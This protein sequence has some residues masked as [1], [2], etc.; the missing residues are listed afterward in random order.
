[1]RKQLTVLLLMVAYFACAQT[2]TQPLYREGQV[3]VKIKSGYNKT[4]GQANCG[5]QTVLQSI[6]G[7]KAKQLMPLSGTMTDKSRKASSRDN[8]GG[9]TDLSGLY[10]IHFD[11]KRSVESTIEALKKLG[12]VAYAEP[13]YIIKAIGMAPKALPNVPQPEVNEVSATPSYNDPNYSEQWGLQAINMPALWEKPVINST[14]P[15]IAV[16]DTGVDIT[17][18]DLAANIWTNTAEKG[19]DE[20]GNGFVG[21]VHG[22][23]FIE[24]TA[25]ITDKNNHGTHCAGIA[26]AVGNNGKGIVGANPNAL[27]MPVRVLDEAALGDVSIIIQGIDYAIANGANVISMSYGYSCPFGPSEAERDALLEASQ[28]AILVAAAGNNGVCMNSEHQGLHGN[29]NMTPMPSYPAAFRFVIGVQASDESGGL[30]SFS[31]FDCG[32]TPPSSWLQEPLSYEVTAPGNNIISTVSGGGYELMNGTSMACP[33]VAGAISSLMQR[34]NF[35]SNQELLTA[36]ALTSQTGDVDMAAVYGITEFPKHNINEVFTSNIDGVDITFKVNTVNTVQVGDGEN[37]AIASRGVKNVTIPLAVDGFQVVSIGRRAFSWTDLETISLPNSLKYFDT[38]A[39]YVANC[40]KELRI[41][42]SV[43]EIGESS[44]TSCKINELIIPKGLTVIKQGAINSCEE[45]VSIKVDEA[46]PKYDSRNSCNAIIETASN[47]LIAGTNTIPESVEFIGK[48]AFL[49]MPFESITIPN[50]VKV[51]GDQSFMCCEKLKQIIFPEGL[52]V[53]GDEAFNMCGSLK[54][55]YIPKTVTSLKPMSFSYCENLTSVVVDPAN[56][57]YDSRGNCN[58]IIETASNTLIEGFNCTTIPNG[59]TGIASNAFYYCRSLESV[60]ISK[61]ITYVGNAAFMGCDKLN[62]IVVVDDNP[63]YDSRDNCNAIIE[64]ATNKL[65]FGNHASTIP[66]SVKIIAHCAF[67]GTEFRDTQITI[68]EGVVKIITQAFLGMYNVTIS[69]PSTIKEIEGDAFP[70][71]DEGQI[72]EVYCYRKT[73]F[74]ISNYVFRAVSTAKLHVPKGQKAA[75]EN[76]KGWKRFGTIVEMDVEG[77]D[78]P[79][80]I[81]PVIESEETTFGGDGNI[82]DEETDLTNVVI[83]NTYYTMDADNGDGYDAEKQ[84][85]VLNS[86]TTK[87]QINTV[88]ESKVGDDAVRDNYSGIIFEVPAGKGEVTVDAQILGLHVLNV[89]IGKREPTKVNNSERELVRINYNVSEPTYVYLYASSDGGSHTRA[90][91]AAANSVLL[92]GYMV[93]LLD[94]DALKGDA[95]NDKEVNVADIVKLVN[96]NAS[97]SE[98]DEVVD[99]IMKK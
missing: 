20:D 31:N 48:R 1:M 17:H 24:G 99:I 41:P 61:D 50:S 92:Y 4:R 43:V 70:V 3:I 98:I 13:N 67:R 91:S 83:E 72:S 32:I 81:E 59:I 58:A 84:A 11:K 26:A 63:V 33:L 35:N 16:L 64:T 9:R 40:L 47:T 51:I 52:T 46:N 34:R 95:N 68:P 90:S 7:T 87:E 85:L 36:L 78:P 80:E 30:A 88:Q 75:Y 71:Y 28:Y 96:D 12:D 18:P 5:L 69:L 97:Q 8:G 45:L 14:R 10:V 39:F 23:D 79:I 21:D 19:N 54:S 73:P 15:V 57:V 38:E 29:P 49:G 56:S 65:I 22:W 37:A 60:T 27:I 55:L 2:S 42:E 86:T 94:K 82:I 62:S 74:P 25:D 89:Q 76:A 77:A 44:I 93:T 6:H 53:I 66:S